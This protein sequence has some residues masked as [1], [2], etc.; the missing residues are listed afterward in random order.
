MK[1]DWKLLETSGNFFY[2]EGVY[3]L[4][5]HRRPNSDEEYDV[6]FNFFPNVL[7]SVVDVRIVQRR[8]S[9]TASRETLLGIVRQVTNNMG[10]IPLRANAGPLDEKFALQSSSDALSSGLR[11]GAEDEEIYRRL[12]FFDFFFFS[13]P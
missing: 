12:F 2:G 9:N 3:V 8:G 4:A 10:W 5:E 1:G 6:E 11:A 13:L 7:E